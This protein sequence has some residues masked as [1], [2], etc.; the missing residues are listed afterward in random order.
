MTARLV[1]LTRGEAI[2]E[3][4]DEL[5]N[6]NGE[7]FGDGTWV[8]FPLMVYERGTGERWILIQDRVKRRTIVD[9]LRTIW[10][11]NPGGW[12][13][14]VIDEADYQYETPLILPYDIL[15]RVV[16]DFPDPDDAA[17]VRNELESLDCPEA[18]RVARCVLHLS[19]GSV[20][21]VSR[22]VASAIRDYRDV[23]LFAEYDRDDRRLHDFSESFDI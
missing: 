11:D 17:K 19:A 2:V 3:I 5:F 13:T 1:N 21:T 15:R 6:V 14:L 16:R 9:A 20:S 10:P 8:V 12:A 4:D 18:A 22:N 7:G 23:I